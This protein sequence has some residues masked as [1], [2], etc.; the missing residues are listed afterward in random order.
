MDGAG[1]GAAGGRDLGL[2]RKVRALTPVV[3]ALG[4]QPPGEGAS[5]GPSAPDPC[6]VLG[7]PRGL[8]LWPWTFLGAHSCPEPREET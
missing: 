6:A 1:E 5:P 4:L 8:L 2:G 7:E 3:V